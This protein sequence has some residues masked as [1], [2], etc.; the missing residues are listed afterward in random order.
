MPTAEAAHAFAS[1]QLQFQRQHVS[2]TYPAAVEQV[3]LNGADAVAGRLIVA[4]LDDS[5]RLV[6]IALL[7]EARG[8]GI[9]TALVRG[10]QERAA[11]LGLPVVLHV[12]HG[13]PARRL[14]ERLGFTATAEDQLR[15]EMRWAPPGS[16]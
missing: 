9:G 11:A 15:T 1:M 2:A 10:V 16:A 4:E 5:V 6:D 7:P 14:Y 12:E 3:V 8:S 13:L